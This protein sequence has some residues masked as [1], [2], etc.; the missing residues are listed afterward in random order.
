MVAKEAP[1]SPMTKFKKSLN[2]LIPFIGLWAALQIGTFHRILTLRCPE[3]IRLG[4]L[5]SLL[6]NK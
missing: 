2:N 5:K 6:A 1:I 3:V 4:G